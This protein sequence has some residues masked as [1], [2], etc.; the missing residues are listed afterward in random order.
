MTHDRHPSPAPPAPGRAALLHKGTVGTAFGRAGAEAG[1]SPRTDAWPLNSAWPRCRVSAPC[2]LARGPW[3]PMRTKPQGSTCCRTHQMNS[4][5]S[6]L[7][8]ISRAGAAL[9]GFLLPVAT[10]GRARARQSEQPERRKTPTQLGCFVS[11]GFRRPLRYT[12]RVA[13]LS[14]HAIKG[15]QRLSDESAHH[16]LLALSSRNPF[17]ELTLSTFT[18]L[19]L[20]FRRLAKT[21]RIRVSGAW[22]GSGLT[23]GYSSHNRRAA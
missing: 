17:P 13:R 22:T 16:S 11:A 20:S 18:P 1:T 23:P 12:A 15:L 4:N 14:D 2:R 3:C 9:V 6:R 7:A 5:A 8:G 19:V 10:A 21:S